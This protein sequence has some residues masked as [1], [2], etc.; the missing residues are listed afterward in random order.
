VELL[1]RCG[2]DVGARDAH[3]ETA[4]NYACWGEH[5]EV[6]RVLAL[7][8]PTRCMQM[9]GGDGLTPMMAAA[10]KGPVAV[11]R[12]LVEAMHRP[13][14]RTRD[15]REDE[16][17][18]MNGEEEEEEWDVDD[19]NAS[20]R[21]PLWYACRYGH[22]EMVQA[23]LENGADGMRRL[24]PGESPWDAAVTHGHVR[25]AELVKVRG[26]KTA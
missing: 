15:S 11:F 21:T 13:R 10:C 12:A 24:G 8:T 6:V 19:V 26:K 18:G 25:C 3:G 5:V 22:G 16:G 4:L 2:A 9:R 23:L 1:V 7:L 17:G 20:G 14:V